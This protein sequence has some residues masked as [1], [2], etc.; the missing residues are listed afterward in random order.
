MTTVE[1]QQQRET[2]R[3]RPTPAAQQRAVL[4]QQSPE[5]DQ[6]VSL[7][8]RHLHS[9]PSSRRPGRQADRCP[10]P[11]RLV[12]APLPAPRH[13][14]INLLGRYQFTATDLTRDELRP[15]RDPTHPQ[16]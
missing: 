7:A 10:K 14:H 16:A 8:L 2:Q 15:L 4:V 5:L 1:L 6:L 9:N 12:T 13:D 3:R 11:L